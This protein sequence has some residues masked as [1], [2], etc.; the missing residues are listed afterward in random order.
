M[1]RAPC[2]IS[3]QVGATDGRPRTAAPP[4]MIAS[5]RLLDRH[6]IAAAAATGDQRRRRRRRSTAPRR[7][8]AA[9]IPEVAQDRRRRQRPPRRR[10]RSRGTGA[11]APRAPSSIE[12]RQS[13]A[14]RPVERRRG[15]GP[16]AVGRRR[17]GRDHPGPGQVPEQG[18]QP[19]A[20][21]ARP[22]TSSCASGVVAA[23]AVGRGASRSASQPRQ[24]GVDLLALDEVH[25]QRLVAVLGQQQRARRRAVAAGAPGLLVVGLERGRHARVHD[26]A[27]VRL[28]HAHAERVGRADHRASSG[29]EAPLH[30]RARRS[31]SSPAWYATAS[32]PSAA[33]ELAGQLLEPA[34]VPA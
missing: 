23:V 2:R 4:T 21:P 16:R 8:P 28:V 10:P 1:L 26:R 15:G 22:R 9:R 6:R 33:L 32:S 5:S 18:P 14:A 11:S 3:A 25:V 7:A 29:E 17:R 30:R 20:V 12:E 27:H 31:R 34:R 13:A 24:P 19:L